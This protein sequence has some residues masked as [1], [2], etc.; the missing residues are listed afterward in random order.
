MI[1][2]GI[3]MSRE[4]FR[5][6]MKHAKPRILKE[7][8]D[9]FS[10]LMRVP[11]N[12]DQKNSELRKTFEGLYFR[13]KDK[14]H[15]NSIDKDRVDGYEYF[16]FETFHNCPFTTKNS[17]F[18]KYMAMI[19]HTKVGEPVEREKVYQAFKDYMEHFNK[20]FDKTE[21]YKMTQWS[22]NHK[23]NKKEVINSNSDTITFTPI[24]KWEKGEAVL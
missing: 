16:D 4:E 9:N 7:L 3:N 21:V 17:Y 14:I 24:K 5:A 2:L 11:V 13:D 20:E 10:N 15:E 19:Y 22:H 1:K 8:A 6:R 23:V 18:D 12:K